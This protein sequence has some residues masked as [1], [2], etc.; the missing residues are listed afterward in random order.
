MLISVVIRA[1][2][3]RRFVAQLVAGSTQKAPRLVDNEY[4]QRRFSFTHRSDVIHHTCR[5]KAPLEERLITSHVPP[6]AQLMVT[7]HRKNS[8]LSQ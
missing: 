2:A 4:E 7:D 3:L 6:H 5:A 8:A 1:S